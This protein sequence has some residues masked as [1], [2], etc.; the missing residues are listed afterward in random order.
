MRLFNGKEK[1]KEKEYSPPPVPSLPD[2]SISSGPLVKTP[3]PTTSRVPVP[4]LSPSLLLHS[5][6]SYFERVISDVSKGDEEQPLSTNV[7]RNMPALSIIPPSETSLRV[8]SSPMSTQTDNRSRS[9][10][11]PDHSER[12]G[13]VP[14][15]APPSTT[16]FPSLSLRPVSTIFSAHFAQH[17]VE[18]D[19]G[20]DTEPEL[21]TST[22]TSGFSPLSP[23]FP[24]R[25][26]DGKGAPPQIVT[27]SDA[28]AIIQS[29]QDQIATSRKAWQRQV[30]ELE[31]RVR[32]LRSEVEELRAK[33]AEGEPCDKCGRGLGRSGEP[34]DS[35]PSVVNRPRARTGV[36]TRFGTRG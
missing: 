34:F 18:S 23:D 19:L 13:F 11:R 32:D 9:T 33:E 1:E 10:L 7:R 28:S 5:G 26:S 31:G 16:E 35:R 4:A 3:K 24:L 30:W 8:P 27:Q 14:A 21:D 29:L 22:S 20:I 2:T 36:G 15:S 12:T 17:L 25:S 6:G